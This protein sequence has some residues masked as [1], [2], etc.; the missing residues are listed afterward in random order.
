MGPGNVKETRKRKEKGKKKQINL[1]TWNVRG[2]YT[3]GSIKE[4][5]SEFKR[6]KI[7][8]MAIQETKQMG[9]DIVE[10]EDVILYKS[11]GENRLLGTGF[12]ILK[13]LKEKVINFKPISE[14]MCA[15]RLKGKNRNI[16]ILNVHA[17]SEEKEEENKDI[18]YEQL[19][20]EYDR[21]HKHDI[22]ILMGDWN[23][24]IGKEDM[25]KRTVGN[26]SKHENTNENGQ[27]V[28]G[29]AMGRNMV[30]RSTQIQRKEIYKDT[31]ISPDKKTVNQIDHVII[32]RNDMELITN[33]RSMRGAEAN[34]DHYLVKV[35]CKNILEEKQM[36]QLN[37]RTI[38]K[39][40]MSKLE[41]EDNRNRYEKEINRRFN[42]LE[43]KT[44]IEEM[45]KDIKNTILATNETVI[46][47]GKE[48]KQ[49]KEW[50]DDECRKMFEE[51]RKLRQEILTNNDNNI[52]EQYKEKRK[53]MKMICRRKKREYNE[54]KLKV[55]EENFK[56]KEIRSFY[57]EV[58]KMGK[59]W[60]NGR[61]SYI[62][63]KEGIMEC[64]PGRVSE[65]WRLYFQELLNGEEDYEEEQTQE[66]EEDNV[67]IAAPTREEV[68]NIIKGLKSN[69]SPGESAITAEMLKCGGI[70]LHQRLYDLIT[71][72]W[73]KVKMPEDWSSALICPLHKKGDKMQ[74]ENYRG[75][76]LLEV[77]YKIL[78]QI[79]R[80]RL[81]SYSEEIIGEYQAGFRGGRSITDQIFVLKEIQASCYEY[82]IPL[83]AIFID[84]KQ[85]YDSVDRRR[86][87]EALREMGIPKKLIMLI[88]MTLQ[89]TK[90]KIMWNGNKSENF[91]TRKGLRQGDP[92]STVLFNL[93]L[94]KIIRNTKIKVNEVIYSNEH[95]CLAYAD[96]LTIVAKSK[97]ELIQIVKQLGGEGK[98]FGLEIN[99]E[100][101]KYMVMGET[102]A[103]EEQLMF[104]TYDGKN[105]SFEKVKTFTYLGVK[106][107]DNGHE[108]QEIKARIAKGNQKYG[109][110][111]TLLKSHYVSRKTKIRIYKTVIRPTTTYASETWIINKDTESRL[112]RW[113][114]KML[115]A[116]YGGINTPEGWRRRTNKEIERLYDEPSIIVCIKAQRLKWLGHVERMARRRTARMALFR[117]PIGKRKK[118]RPRK[119]WY[120]NA[121][122]DLKSLNVADWR[123]RAKDRKTWKDVVKRFIEK[124]K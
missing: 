105:Y 102:E 73:E 95:Q 49:G 16:S 1:A 62:T 14:R 86:M 39:Y 4:L 57:Q 124:R 84:Y 37:R 77:C 25:Y 108:E 89:V 21:L 69:K 64:E 94:E 23:A 30:I 12:M 17:L 46:P 56:N 11:G 54:R 109:S 28:I 34:S 19:E 99:Q 24:K 35:V 32:G 111:R 40:D 66:M 83:F 110:L 51:I 96:D 38:R 82:K 18:W 60:H 53:Q 67:R 33:V 2:T 7:E 63:N 87:Y 43:T 72:I 26:H 97:K 90:N 116:I 98:K 91:E 3:P 81:V 114:R 119:R 61:S 22:K 71:N 100:K 80:K 50:F 10:I 76:A 88:R 74:C 8:V 117:R 29:F 101:T 58:K 120:E 113:E 44:Q 47:K 36:K 107:Q 31:W 5:I 9:S 15:I 78:A 70:E 48:S 106:I 45:W 52:L 41:K 13:A 122:E 104:Q 121:E 55:I 59:Q 115:R 85:A 118:G 92:M 6:Y 93:V 75:I 27:R 68:N 79:V 123:S 65:V 20:K 42:G 112:E 103:E